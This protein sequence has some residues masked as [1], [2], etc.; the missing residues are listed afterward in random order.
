M[1]VILILAALWLW[2][3]FALGAQL[4]KLAKPKR[5]RVMPRW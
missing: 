1:K 4:K 2:Q 3:K 5:M